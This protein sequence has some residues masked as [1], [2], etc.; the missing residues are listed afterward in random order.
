MPCSVLAGFT[1]T[2]SG[3]GIYC[4]GASPRICNCRIVDNAQAGIKLWETNAANP[5]FANCIIAGNGG[6]GIEMVSASGGRSVKYNCAT[7]LHCT[8]V[9][10]VKEG[11]LGG[12]SIIV[13]SIVYANGRG[14]GTRQID[15]HA[16]IVSGCNIE[17]G[18]PGTDNIDVEPGFVA[19]GFW[20]PANDLS[21]PAPAGDSSAV[22]AP[23]DYHLRQDSACVDAGIAEA[24]FGWLATDMDGDPRV[25]GGHPDIGCDEFVPAP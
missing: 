24:I 17:G 12:D 22:W 25:A 16:A 8:I 23:G 2:N 20:T 14:G 6:A 1:I 10:N 15:A 18:Y 4:R 13:N 21:R 7:V 3:Q 9:G 19:P 5:T 11:I